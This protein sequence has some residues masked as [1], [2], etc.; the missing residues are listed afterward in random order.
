MEK[1]TPLAKILLGMDKS[2]PWNHMYL[3]T[4]R[5]LSMATARIVYREPVKQICVTGSKMGTSMG[6]ICRIQD[7]VQFLRQFSQA[8]FEKEQIW[9][10]I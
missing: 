8:V 9:E 5:N 7:N 4:A 3:V 1:F 10:M 6:K 2:H